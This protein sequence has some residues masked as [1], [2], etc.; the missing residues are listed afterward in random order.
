MDYLSIVKLL[1][2]ILEAG[3]L[4]LVFLAFTL[5]GLAARRSFVRAVRAGLMITAGF[6]GVYILVGYFLSELAPAA[7]AVALRFGGAL[8]YTDNGWRTFYSFVF[9]WPATYG[10]VALCLLVNLVMLLLSMTDTLNLNIRDYWL[11]GLAAMILTLL[12]GSL[13]AGLIFAAFLVWASLMLS[14]FFAQRGYGAALGLPGLTLF[15]GLGTLWSVFSHYLGLLLDKAGYKSASQENPARVHQVLTGEPALLGAILGLILGFGAGYYWVDTALLVISLVIVL[16]LLPVMTK[17]L[18][19]ALAD[20]QDESGAILVIGR[21]RSQINIGD[22]T[23]VA[24]GE[25]AILTAAVLMVPITLVMSLVIPGVMSMP[26]ADLVSLML[27]WVL[28]AVPQRFNL[29][30]TLL[31]CTLIVLF[32]IF[33]SARGVA[34][35]SDLVARNAGVAAPQG[36]GI[37]S[38]FNHLSPE[39]LTAGLLGENFEILGLNG[40]ILVSAAG[41]LVTAIFRLNY[42]RKQ[43]AGIDHFEK[44]EQQPFKRTE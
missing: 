39:M 5:I 8:P 25:P 19:Q 33:A 18:R 15:L 22:D 14:D 44:V 1:D 21:S 43:K 2:P 13:A 23:S 9:A 35:W 4:L 32:G 26:F 28:A 24:A 3:P 36:M 6:G 42:L 11:A 12:S 34:Y 10:V 41:V 40:I 20:L 16:V 29:P 31:A 38:W 37:T 30:R 17:I 27:F 7:E